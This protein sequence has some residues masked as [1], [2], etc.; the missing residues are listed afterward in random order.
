MAP[1]PISNGLVILL[2]KVKGDTCFNFSFCSAV[3]QSPILIFKLLDCGFQVLGMFSRNVT[4][5]DI[6]TISI[7]QAKTFGVT[8]SP[9]SVVYPP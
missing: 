5:L 8:V 3:C 1:W 2:A 7:P 6:P 4:M 9:T